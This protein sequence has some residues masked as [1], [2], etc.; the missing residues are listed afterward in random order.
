MVM[1]LE[2]FHIDNNAHPPLPDM[3]HPD[4]VKKEKKRSSKNK[5]SSSS[6]SRSSSSGG[7]GGVGSSKSRR[8]SS[9]R[10]HSSRSSRTSSI[11]GDEIDRAKLNSNALAKK[12][13]YSAQVHS[14]AAAVEFATLG[15]QFQILACCAYAATGRS[16]AMSTRR[17]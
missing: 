1:G 14:F 8:S 7:G 4:D 16:S 10:N 2:D 12:R 15:G 9:S 17:R 13:S 5:S 6:S 11:G 3:P